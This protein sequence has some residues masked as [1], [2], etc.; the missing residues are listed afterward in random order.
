MG[1]WYSEAL[2]MAKGYMI[3]LRGLFGKKGLG[4]DLDVSFA[5]IFGG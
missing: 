2:E 5:G 1:P 4:L 3:N